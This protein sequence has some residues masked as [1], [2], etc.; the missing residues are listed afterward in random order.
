MRFGVR[1]L[2]SLWWVLIPVTAVAQEPV[3]AVDVSHWSGTIT[4]D[5]VAC[6]KANG[7][8]PVYD[9]TFYSWRVRAE[10]SLGWGAWSHE[11]T[12]VF[13]NV[14]LPPSDDDGTWAFPV[15]A[16]ESGSGWFV[17]LGLGESWYSNFLGR[18]FRGHLGEDWFRS[19][20]GTLG[21]P[22]F[23]A[24]DGEVVTVLQNC[25]N[26]V[27]VVILRHD[28]DGIDEPV[29][30]FYGHIESDGYV[31]EGD[32]VTKRQQIGVIGD[33]VDFNPHLHF[34]IKNE[35]ALVNPPFS[36]C[37]NVSQ[38]LYIS[39][40]YSGLA[41]DDDGGSFYDPSDSVIGNRY[42]HPSSFLEERK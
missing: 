13:G 26:Y 42:Y 18:W 29:Y 1:A 33:P 35:T 8:E 7:V 17:S 6:W 38:G 32:R 36:G 30:T 14:D 39:A 23:A 27:D 28:V 15:G 41:N 10:N 22:V 9:D 31:S 12:F 2:C 4:A 5:E 40:G 19:G 16:A 21:Q 37:S 24:A 11:A 3:F 20:G 34:E 25:G